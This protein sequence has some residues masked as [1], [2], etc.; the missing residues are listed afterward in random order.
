V[1]VAQNLSDGKWLHFNDG[2][3]KAISAAQVRSMVQPADGIDPDRIAVDDATIA[4]VAEAASSPTACKGD[5]AA[6]GATTD[7]GAAG[8]TA[9]GT[10]A[11]TE[12]PASGKGAGAATVPSAA[13][14]AYMLV[15]RRVDADGSRPAPVASALLPEVRVVSVW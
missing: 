5:A 9:T 12:T 2:V 11:T 3:V 1:I 14:N 15:Y 8:A 10:T 13:A 7:T 6:A 4:A